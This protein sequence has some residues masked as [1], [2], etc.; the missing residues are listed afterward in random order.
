M[1]ILVVFQAQR[2]RIMC[3][4]DMARWPWLGD[5]TPQPVNVHQRFFNAYSQFLI[6]V[7]LSLT[8]SAYD[9]PITAHIY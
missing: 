8:F 2:C 3:Q 1:K 4:V 9:T 7:N 5:I 6:Y